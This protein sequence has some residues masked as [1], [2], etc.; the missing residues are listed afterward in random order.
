M[1]RRS[2]GFLLDGSGIGSLE[3]GRYSANPEYDRGRRE[4]DA[5]YQRER[6]RQS[7]HYP[8]PSAAHSWL[9]GEREVEERDTVDLSEFPS[10]GS[11]ADPA[12]IVS[13]AMGLSET[14]RRGANLRS[15][16]SNRRLPDILDERE[17]GNNILNGGEPGPTSR[18]GGHVDFANTREGARAASPTGFFV[19]TNT[20][21]QSVSASTLSI[22][23]RQLSPLNPSI[24][25]PPPP[26]G[27]TTGKQNFSPVSPLPLPP[28]VAPYQQLQSKRS[29][30]AQ[31]RQQLREFR[32]QYQPT[33]AT[34]QRALKAKQQLELSSLYKRLLTIYPIHDLLLSG[35]LAHGTPN[36]GDTTGPYSR[37]RI[38]NPLMAIRNKR[39][40]NRERIKLELSSWDDPGA[41][42]QWIED[43]V[44]AVH[45]HLEGGKIGLPRLPP[46]PHP[47]GRVEEKKRARMDWVISPQELLADFYWMEES[48]R[49]RIDQTQRAGGKVEENMQEGQGESHPSLKSL[50]DRGERKAGSPSQIRKR[51]IR[52]LDNID[53]G[54]D[55]TRRDT[56][57]SSKR[58]SK[59]GFAERGPSLQPGIQLENDVGYHS[60]YTSQ[61]DSSHSGESEGTCDDEMSGEEIDSDIDQKAK[62]KHSK[63][64]KL[65]KIITGTKPSRRKR[66]KKKRISDTHVLSPEEKR[67]RQEQ[68]EMEW[69]VEMG[70]RLP[71]RRGS[72][73]GDEGTDPATT[74]ALARATAGKTPGVRNIGTGVSLPTT[75]GGSRSSL[76]RFGSI[77]GPAGRRSLD[78]GEIVVPSIAIS[79]SPPKVTSRGGDEDVD[80]RG[81]TKRKDEMEGTRNEKRKASPTKK[82][83][84]KSMEVMG[85][86][87]ESSY[88]DRHKESMD[89]DNGR[90]LKDKDKDGSAMGRVKSRVEKIRSEVAKVED[91]IWRRDAEKG[92]SALSSPT[93]SSFAEAESSGYRS[94]D[95][96]GKL[97]KENTFSVSEVED[98]GRGSKGKCGGS[99][100]EVP[101]GH[102]LRSSRFGSHSSTSALP[103]V[104]KIG[105]RDNYAEVSSDE[106]GRRLRSQKFG[107]NLESTQP[108]ISRDPSPARA[109]DIRSIGDRNGVKGGAVAQRGNENNG[110]RLEK[111]LGSNDGKGVVVSKQ[112]LLR[113]RAYLLAS[114]VVARGITSKR[115]GTSVLGRTSDNNDGVGI[116]ALA[117]QRMHST[118]ISRE[119]ASAEVEFVKKSRVFTNSTVVELK[120]LVDNIKSE[121][122]TRLATMLGEV[123]DGAGE[124]NGE[125]T[126]KCTLAVKAVNDDLSNV[127]RRKRRRFRWIRRVG[128]VMLEWVVLGVMWWV[129]LVVVVV[130]FLRVTVTWTIRGVR[131]ILWI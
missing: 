17:T 119:I 42:E 10:H 21:G 61:E 43:L 105:I 29:A 7:N 23:G 81:R 36:R 22:F 114:G 49:L 104:P 125:L 83:L 44:V 95:D 64:K 85:R 117:E 53:S 12:R 98:E 100:L 97:V 30:L 123:A 101:E 59:P 68:E 66:A 25:S 131:W 58:R 110:P 67:R 82:L 31:H 106:E 15:L 86:E 37:E 62:K 76:E 92:G 6:S 2:G 124:L 5:G 88:D 35:S 79:L 126:T 57:D 14:R 65:G 26:A 120:G 45:E 74:L 52:D 121:I 113:A 108:C 75:L 122:E 112:A 56:G 129:W 1:S 70:D 90:K 99:P 109:I 50:I 16:S 33:E 13:L 34:L 11:E 63:R 118:D 77:G 40:R 9:P 127:M 84:E 20:S 3:G 55:I 116:V 130:R 47:S 73:S 80:L 48:E 46:P 60:A 128:Y 54:D 51:S 102:A 71:G 91:F 27:G 28:P 115:A 103:T 24:A 72:Y 69:M 89:S 41:V 8:E 38:Y 107:A 96:R 93:G 32:E 87:R 19:G 18:A 94:E 78:F 4:T 39:F 111:R